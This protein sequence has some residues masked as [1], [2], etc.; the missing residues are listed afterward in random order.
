MKRKIILLLLLL[1]LI[2]PTVVFHFW[3]ASENEE[4]ALSISRPPE[5]PTPSVEE[6]FHSLYH[7]IETDGSN[8][9]SEFWAG[10]AMTESVG[11]MLRSHE[12]DKLEAIAAR[13][14]R[15]TLRH[16]NGS[17]V[18][19]VFY[20][21]LANSHEAELRSLDAM[22]EWAH[23]RPQTVTPLLV[24]VEAYTHHAWDARGGGWVYQVSKGSL[25][26][27]EERLKRA[28]EFSRQAE[29]ITTNET[30]LYGARMWLAIGLNW[31][32]DEMEKAFKQAIAIDPLYYHAYE[33]KAVYLLPRW[34]GSTAEHREFV[35]QAPARYLHE[36]GDTLFWRLAAN[37]LRYG[38]WDHSS[39]DGLVYLSDPNLRNRLFN[40]FAIAL[41]RYPRSA[42]TRFRYAHFA[43]KTGDVKKAR[44][45]LQPFETNTINGFIRS[46]YAVDAWINWAKTE[47][48]EN[49]MIT[50]F[51]L[52]GHLPGRAVDFSPDGRHI[53]IGSEGCVTIRN[54]TGPEFSIIQSLPCGDTEIHS[55][56][57]SPDGKQL[58]AGGGAGN[59]NSAN[60]SFDIFL[61]NTDDWTRAKPLPSVG[62]ASVLRFTPD[63]KSL[64]VAGGRV[65]RFEQIEFI[66]LKT[67]QRT[68]IKRIGLNQV[69]N[70]FRYEDS[71]DYIGSGGQAVFTLH[72]GKI[73]IAGKTLAPEPI[74]GM[75]VSRGGDF[76][77]C[78]R[79]FTPRGKHTA[80]GWLEMWDLKTWNAVSRF[81]NATLGGVNSIVISPDNR[82]LLAAGDDMLVSM[83]D[84]ETGNR[85]ADLV[86]HTHSIRDMALSPDGSLLVT[87]GYDGAV[88]L[89]DW[90]KALPSDHVSRTIHPAPAP[91]TQR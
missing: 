42:E 75:A 6:F 80:R 76:L 39:E 3:R 33:T 20:S 68:E 2:P 53:A 37:T 23:Q 16:A 62:S 8:L 18:L 1:L 57:Y 61:W 86:G 49:P 78:G 64:I 19:P 69:F 84:I 15:E 58:A 28:E 60:E 9:V 88:I 91:A 34:H 31:E 59:P 89:W 71:D 63:A 10:G 26:L 48:A 52:P 27:F 17:P 56:R 90:R 51:T 24:L 4:L 32:R 7:A 67:L 65:N 13:L 25:S 11:R 43:L 45:L 29:L 5:K 35:E 47:T 40:S 77:F 41:K 79:Y 22:E 14:R 81:E 83:W 54:T 82:L 55:V 36:E 50:R 66:D 85:V 72:K 30:H 12:F 46:P 21:T 44:E 70:M 74:G 87:T 38:S 73:V